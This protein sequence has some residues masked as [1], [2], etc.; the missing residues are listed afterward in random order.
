MNELGKPDGPRSR[1]CRY[2]WGDPIHYD[3][4]GLK[5]NEKGWTDEDWAAFKETGRV[6]LQ[7]A[8]ASVCGCGPG[9]VRRIDDPDDRT[10][11]PTAPEYE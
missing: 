6:E 7:E 2:W 3:F 4:G 11:Y 9:P 1:G 10:P 8:S 5:P